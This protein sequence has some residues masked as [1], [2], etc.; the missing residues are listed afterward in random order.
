M[1]M[2]SC[3]KTAPCRWTTPCPNLFENFNNVKDLV[4][5]CRRR[6]TMTTRCD[7]QQADRSWQQEFKGWTQVQV[8]RIFIHLLNTW[9]RLIDWLI[10]HSYTLSLRYSNHLNTGLVWYSNGRFVS[11]CKMVC[12]QMVVWKPYW[13]K[14]VYGP[15]CPVFKMSAKSCDF[16]SWIPD[17]H[18]VWYSDE[19]G[20]Q[21][22]TVL[23]LVSKHSADQHRH[24][25]L[26]NVS[27]LSSFLR[28]IRTI[29]SLWNTGETGDMYHLPYCRCIISHHTHLSSRNLP[30]LRLATPRFEP[31]SAACEA[32]DIQLC[33]HT[34]ES[35]GLGHFTV[36]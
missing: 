6:L 10:D 23:L 32:D 25:I 36:N 20:I 9:S 35:Q 7:E 2:R 24:Q 27:T 5:R 18:T 8:T 30:I 12:I 13:K 26:W 22:V 19:S 34:P 1:R 11:G 14:P 4:D 33:H 21:M 17:T 15:K 16:T 28:P 31:G 29:T 3:R